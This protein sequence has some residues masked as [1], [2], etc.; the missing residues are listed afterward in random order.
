MPE[1]KIWEEQS[2]N[3]ESLHCCWTIWSPLLSSEVHQPLDFHQPLKLMPLQVLPRNSHRHNLDPKTA[4]CGC[5]LLQE[6]HLLLEFECN[7][8]PSFLSGLKSTIAVPSLHAHCSELV[9]GNSGCTL[10]ALQVLCCSDVSQPDVIQFGLWL[11]LL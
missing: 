7:W 9:G 3:F 4:E 11:Y 1:C 8:F 10:F 5:M 2:W 6:R